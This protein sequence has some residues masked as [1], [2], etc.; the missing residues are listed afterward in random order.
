MDDKENVKEAR[1]S[2]LKFDVLL[3]NSTS[4]NSC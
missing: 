4:A 1:M 3:L 2:L